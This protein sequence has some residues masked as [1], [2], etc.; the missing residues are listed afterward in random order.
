MTSE[1]SLLKVTIRLGDSTA[2]VIL[3]DKIFDFTDTEVCADLGLRSTCSD[4]CMRLAWPGIGFNQWYCMCTLDLH[5]Q[6]STSD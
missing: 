6:S 2:R 5:A 4:G 3:L 1:L